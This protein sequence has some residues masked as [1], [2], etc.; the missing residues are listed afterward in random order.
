MVDR[1]RDSK[2]LTTTIAVM[3]ALGGIGPVS[4]VTGSRPK[5]TEN[6]SRAKTFPARY[7]L[8]MTHALWRKGYRADPELWGQVTPAERK[9][10]LTAVVAKLVAA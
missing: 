9:R 7:F 5:N 10:A 4:A 8:V 1:K 3:Q 6:W 2:T